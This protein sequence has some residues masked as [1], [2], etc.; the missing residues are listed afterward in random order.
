MSQT[1]KARKIRME[2]LKAFLK[3]RKKTEL[4][5]TYRMMLLTY[6]VSRNQINEYIE[7]LIIMEFVKRNDD[8]IIWIG[9]ET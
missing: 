6:G 4:T 9:K 5:E 7:D 8:H 2:T 3:D 1:L